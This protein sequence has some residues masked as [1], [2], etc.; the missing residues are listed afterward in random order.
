MDIVLPLKILINSDDIT[1][2]VW[3]NKFQSSLE[4]FNVVVSGASPMGLVAAAV[5]S[6]KQLWGILVGKDRRGIL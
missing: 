4:T 2:R 1:P 6:V 5:N 3:K